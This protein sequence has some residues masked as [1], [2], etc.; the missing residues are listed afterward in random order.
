MFWYLHNI[1]WYIRSVIG[2]RVR[3]TLIQST[4]WRRCQAAKHWQKRK[5]SELSVTLNVFP[6]THTHGHHHY[7]LIHSDFMVAVFVCSIAR[8]HYC[9]D[10]PSL[11]S[12]HVSH[13]NSI[14]AVCFREEILHRIEALCVD[15]TGA[16]IKGE[17]PKLSFDSRASW[18]ILRL[19]L[20]GHPWPILM[21]Y[22]LRSK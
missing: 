13:L 7:H 5:Q 10:L 18:D 4:L 21:H 9:S 2:V 12:V 15:V 1:D 22:D 14:P 11:L 8:L 16:I 20:N 6:P 19:V 3:V 17:V